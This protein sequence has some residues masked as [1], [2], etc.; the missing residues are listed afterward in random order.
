MTIPYNPNGGGRGFPHPGKPP[1]YHGGG[2]LGG[3]PGLITSTGGLFGISGLLMAPAINQT[4]GRSF[5]VVFDPTNFSC[6]E[7]AQYTY[8]QEANYDK[9]PGE[10]REASIHLLILKYRELGVASF[11]VNITVFKKVLDDFI[12]VQIPVNIPVIP[13]AKMTKSRRNNFPDG[14]I[15]TVRLEPPNGVVQGERPQVTYTINANAGPVSVTKLIM[16]GNADETP[17][18]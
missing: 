5:I 12:T 13:L 11:S 17:Q 14:R 7:Q 2:N 10:G 3:S 18:Q 15:H 9:I 1:T 8:R 16:C 4:T 6:E